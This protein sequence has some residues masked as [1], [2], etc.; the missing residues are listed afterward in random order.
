MTAQTTRTARGTHR[1]ARRLGV[2]LTGAAVIGSALLIPSTMASAAATAPA[3][4]TAGNSG[5]TVSV[6]PSATPIHPG[7]DSTVS[8]RVINPGSDPVRVTLSDRGAEL[9]DNGSVHLQGAPDPKWAG[10][11]TL[12]AGELTIPA[13]GYQTVNVQIHAPEVIDPDLYFVGLMVT[14]EATKAGSVQVVNQIGTLISLDVPGPRQQDLSASMDASPVQFADK[15]AA[16]L[17]VRNPGHSVLRFFGETG[18]SDA[19]HQPDRIDSSILPVDRQRSLPV[20]AKAAWPIQMVTMDARLSYSDQTA[21]ATTQKTATVDVL[22]VQPWVSIAAIS[23]LLLGIAVPVFRR[24]RAKIARK[25]AA[26]PAGE[27]ALAG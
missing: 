16:T 4:A 26:A 8:I 3:D 6:P 25:R 12:P 15:A 17:Q 19:S 27:P 21:A 13:Q 14:P 7:Q 22:L 9:G 10:R 2:A 11:V 24:I 23:A 18:T 5:L 20:T 1:A